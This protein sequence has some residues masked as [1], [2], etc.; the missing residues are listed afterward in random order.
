VLSPASAGSP[1]SRLEYR[2][3]AAFVYNFAKFVEWPQAVGYGGKPFVIGV[4]GR[5]PF[6][7]IL[8]DTVNGKTVR[9]RT[10]VIQRL[11]SWAQAHEC[12]LL[13]VSGSE[14]KR[15]PESLRGIGRGVLVV[16]DSP[17][18]VLSGGMIGLINE[19]SKVRFEINELAAE[20][21]GLK[22]SS[23]LLKLAR[24]VTRN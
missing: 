17:D 1:D 18:F 21:A 15:L 20:R 24:R 6:G 14:N 23:Q 19:D 3:K 9:G 8:D 7:R 11:S 4:L 12:D 10:L 22:I 2:V 5:D 13:F 16:G